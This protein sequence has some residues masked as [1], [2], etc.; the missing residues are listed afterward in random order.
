MGWFEEQ[1]AL[2]QEADDEAFE[3]SF[4]R[5]A[6]AV[7]GKKWRFSHEGG[8]RQTEDA[9]GEIL[10]FYH[11]KQRELPEGKTE[12]NEVLDYLL[13][14]NGIMTRKVR[15]TPGFSTDAAGAMLARL[16]SGQM[17]ALIPK[18]F[19]GYSY[20]DPVSG[21]TLLLRREREADFAEEAYVFYKPF[22]MKALKVNSL[23]LYMWENIEKADLFCFLFLSGL[24]ALAGL[25]VPF[26][27]R[28]LF[29][30]VLSSNSTSIL[31]A[32]AV[33]MVSASIASI[34]F[35]T[36]KDLG[37]KR[38]SMKLDMSV[39]AATMMRLLSLPAS[40]FKDYGA[41]ELTD[42]AEYIGTLVD[43]IL[44]TGFYTGITALFS[45][46]YMGAIFSFAPMLVVPSLIITGLTVIISLAAALIEIPISRERMVLSAKEGGMGY[47]LLSGIQKI[48]L[49]GAEKRAF[50]RWGRLY[51]AEA[52]Y[53]YDPPL[54]IKINHVLI[55]AIGL[56]GAIIIYNLAVR[57]GVGI[58]E[59]YAFI[60]AFGVVSVSFT[61]L[62]GVAVSLS[63]I[64]PILD[65]AAPIM[66][67]VPEIAEEKEIVER[68]S[69]GIELSNVSFRYSE[70]MPFVIENVSLKIRPGQ[71]VA[72]VGPTGCGKSTLMRLMLGFESPDKGAI[73]YDGRDLKRI[74]L[75]SLRS[76]IGVVLQNS[77]VFTGDICSNIL[78]TAPEL[79]MEDAWRAAEMSGLADD[80]REMPMGMNTQISEGQGGISGGQRQR[81]MIARAVASRPKILMFD[82]ATSALDNITQK[83]VS[84]ALDKLRCT[85]I[86]IAH[87]LSTIKHCDRILVFDKGR[88]IEGGSYE[89]LMERQGFFA[90]LVQRQ[91][92]DEG[93]VGHTTAF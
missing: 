72:I 66:E 34:L 76:R 65:M 61:S 83:K 18:G 81:L 37:L 70:G 9:I 46:C 19:G 17:A 4:Q 11:V 85:R 74:D 38:I 7:L 86:V 64:K 88:V 55:Q 24:S 67:A 2:R 8:A 26:L 56:F 73:Y 47:A 53:A 5:I 51:A 42:R 15:L 69:G 63:Q 52:A 3:D 16:K 77:R 22:P 32:M 21:D 43:T 14:P 40:F 6:G 25:L 23:L 62:T 90:E 36:V 50:A 39:R 48:R 1:I 93:F 92:L 35:E 33:F 31:I 84:D 80:I 60:S 75:K 78:L 54:F 29:S 58:S 44:N 57:S 79:T 87:R 10:R 59:Y 45:L 28:I 41:G 82:E 91:Q 13:R 49:A 89:E 20:K 68:L 30:E 71:Y 12:L 27:S